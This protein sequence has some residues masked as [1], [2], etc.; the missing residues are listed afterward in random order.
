MAKNKIT[1]REII[2][3][4]LADESITSNNMY[5]EFLAHELELLDKKACKKAESDSALEVDFIKEV[6]IEVL[7]RIGKGTVTEIQLAD[8]RIGLDKF[9]NQKIS[10]TLKKMVEVDETV[11]RTTEKRKAIFYLNAVDET[12]EEESFEDEV[13]AE[14]ESFEVDETAEEISE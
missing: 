10:A 11:I 9:R 13:D 12:A 5:K 2:T 7:G 14:E 8:D 6:I 3:L 1:K 4:M